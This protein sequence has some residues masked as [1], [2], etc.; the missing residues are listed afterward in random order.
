M[1]IN[2]LNRLPKSLKTKLKL[3]RGTIAIGAITI[4][5]MFMIIVSCIAAIVME[6]SN[7]SN[8]VQ[9]ATITAGLKA[10]ENLLVQAS[11]S[12]GTITVNVTNEGSTPSIVIALLTV[13][14]TDSSI[15]YY[16]LTQPLTCTVLGQ[17]TFTVTLQD[18]QTSHIGVLTSLGNIFWQIQQPSSGSSPTPP[19]TQSWLVGW[20]Y[21][22]S[23]IINS[24]AGAGTNYQVKI[25]VNYGSGTDNAGNVYLNSHSKVDFGDIRFTDG[26]GVTLLSYW[27]ESEV[28]QNYAVFWVKIPDDLSSNQA[29]IYIYYGNPTATTASNGPGT[30]LMFKDIVADL[31]NQFGTISLTTYSN[32]QDPGDGFAQSSTT[33]N[34]YASPCLWFRYYGGKQIQ[35]TSS[36]IYLEGYLNAGNYGTCGIDLRFRNNAAPTWWQPSNSITAD[37]TINKKHIVALDYSVSGGASLNFYSTWLGNSDDFPT[38]TVAASYSLTSATRT[39]QEFTYSGTIAHTIVGHQSLGDA[40]T[41]YHQ[42]YAIAKYA[43]SEPTHGSWGP[44][45]TQP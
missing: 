30:F 2:R 13:S 41:I 38:G 17:G 29:P 37:T 22:K 20:Q 34:A 23:H 33:D 19:P 5:L 16:N 25:T 7:Y 32:G 42:Y 3:K 39:T 11:N 6:Y 10:K 8:G 43:S 36:Y 31:Q 18:Q 14:S 24:A 44:E 12:T 9:V 28:N 4:I 21:Q 26:D 45:T 15:H 40:I 35:I 1:E 27:M